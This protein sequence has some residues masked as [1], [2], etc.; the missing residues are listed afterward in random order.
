M[1]L[2]KRSYEKQSEMLDGK[3]FVCRDL[4]GEYIDKNPFGQGYDK[5]KATKG[6]SC[7]GKRII[8][9]FINQNIEKE[10]IL[11]KREQKLYDE[12]H[13]YKTPKSKKPFWKSGLHIMEHFGPPLIDKVHKY[14]APPIIKYDL[15]QPPFR[16]PRIEGDYFDKDIR[17]LGPSNS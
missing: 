13:D 5:E 17:L 14:K 11:M 4:F 6:L 10:K 1:P 15:V 16:R 8:K 9:S 2:V 7:D 12:V 3:N